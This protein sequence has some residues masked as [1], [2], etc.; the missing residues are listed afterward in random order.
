MKP[1]EILR[2]I[3]S[4]LELKPTAMPKIKEDPKYLRGM[5]S[6]ATVKIKGE[7]L[8]IYIKKKDDLGVIA[9]EL[10][11]LADVRSGTP[12]QTKEYEDCFY[13][14][15]L[16]EALGYYGSKL[17]APERKPI[18]V[19]S[20]ELKKII[21]EIKVKSKLKKIKE[22]D[23]KKIRNTYQGDLDLD[24]RTWHE[25]GYDLGEEVY[26]YVRRTGKKEP[27]LLLVIKNRQE[28]KQ[29]FET[30]KKILKKVTK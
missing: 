17:I 4:Y 3:E 23:W 16:I 12:T 5:G 14:N 1:K 22:K 10:T 25:I 18:N 27:A 19:K 28:E 9:E 2:T 13:G 7:P 8:T 30:Y 29:P 11:H 24:R 26:N 6:G 15:V 20:A 21:E